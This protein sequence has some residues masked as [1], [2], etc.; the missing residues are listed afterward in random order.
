M[1]LH[2]ELLIIFVVLIS[3][4]VFAET[5]TRFAIP[6]VLGEI[7]AGIILGPSGLMWIETGA[8]LH[9][10][11]EIG[12]ILLLF[13]VGLKSR[14]KKLLLA[15]KQSFIVASDGLVL[16]FVLGLICAK[17]LFETSWI[18]AF[19]IGGTLTATSI[20]VTMRILEQLGIANSNTAEIVLGAAV[21]D[22][23]F[24]VI[25]LSIIY[26]YAG[27]GRV[28]LMH[29][30]E[31]IAFIAVY[32][33]ITPPAVRLI[34]TLIEYV[35]KRTELPGLVPVAMVS[36]VLFFAWLA[37][38]IGVPAIM[39]GFAAGLALSKEFLSFFK[40]TQEDL[41]FSEQV[42]T[43]LRPI[44][45]LFT[46]I[47]FVTVGLSLDL[48]SI[49]WGSPAIWGFSLVFTAL[50]V[51]G[52]FGGAV[53]LP[54]QWKQRAFIG[55]CMVPRGEVSIVFA[56]LGLT[57]GILSHDLYT[58][59]IVMIA[60]VILVSPFWIKWFYKYHLIQNDPLA[61]PSAPH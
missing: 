47:F 50:A 6:A 35:E 54:V 9:T 34:S 16:P 33:L 13:D 49:D 28:N 46:P 25:L 58:G 10:L 17:L 45:Q 52:K 15:G 19:F 26:E 2:T 1:L 53:F 31:V 27:N 4:R 21:I 48:K 61:P 55:M 12:I 23:I 32:V 29:G 41:E 57:A 14:F 60:Y 30:I 11:A 5:A 22:D 43:Q 42:Q 39:G 3:A 51:I 24:G 18:A 44:I 38:L 40:S 36:L 20:G 56:K 7:F 59:L 8:T 37:E